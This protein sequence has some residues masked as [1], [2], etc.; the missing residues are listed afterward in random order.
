MQIKYFELAKS[1][2]KFSNFKF[3]LGCVIVNKNKVIAMGHN[4]LKTHPRSPSFYKF[5]HAETHALIKSGRKELKGS[6]VYVARKL[7]NGNSALARPCIDCEK[8]LLEAGVENI[9]FT[10]YMGYGKI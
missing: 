7:K 10:D 2:C 9:Y 6:D 1:M 8:A 4:S 5:L 3:K